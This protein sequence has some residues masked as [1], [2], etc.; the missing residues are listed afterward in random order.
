[1]DLFYFNFIL[2]YALA[3]FDLFSFDQEKAFDGVDHI[4]LFKTLKAFGFVKQFHGLSH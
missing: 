3:K 4:Y 1:M 2:C